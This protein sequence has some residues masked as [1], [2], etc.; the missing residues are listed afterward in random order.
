MAMFMWS[1]CMVL[2]LQSLEQ[3]KNDQKN[4]S[5]RESMPSK[6]ETIA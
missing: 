6:R 3:F 2:Y 4:L 5:Q 1:G